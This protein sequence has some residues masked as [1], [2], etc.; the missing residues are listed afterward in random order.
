MERVTHRLATHVLFCSRSTW[1]IALALRLTSPAKSRVL[2]AGSISGVD[3][4][5]F[6]PQAGQQFRRDQR[7]RWGL[8]DQDVVV[9]YVGRLLAY[10]GIETLLSAWSQMSPQQRSGAALILI[11]GLG[12]NR[13]VQL[14]EQAQA[15]GE[16]VRFVGWCDDMVAAY[17]AMDLLVLPSWHEGLPYSLLEAQSM[18][19]PVI[20]SNVTGNVDVVVDGQSGLIVPVRDARALAEAMAALIASPAERERLGRFGR[21]WVVENFRQEL[22]QQY[23]VDFYKTI[24][25]AKGG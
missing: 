22:M 23:L 4:Q 14:V 8:S 17:G 15:R 10:K 3:T 24:S 13:M 2:G 1:R 9:G 18:G 20:A 21:Q 7:A 19:L 12:E 11:G 16:G 6:S 25:D 5:R